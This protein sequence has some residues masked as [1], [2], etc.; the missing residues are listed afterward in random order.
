MWGLAK[1][2]I[3]QWVGGDIMVLDS[4]VTYERISGGVRATSDYQLFAY[5]A[6][7][8]FVAKV[9]PHSKTTGNLWIPA[10]IYDGSE[11]S[12]T[13]RVVAREGDPGHWLYLLRQTTIRDP[14]SHQG[15]VDIAVPGYEGRSAWGSV[16][17]EVGIRFAAYSQ[18]KDFWDYTASA[19]LPGRISGVVSDP[20]LGQSS[21]IDMDSVRQ[22]VGLGNQV[23]WVGIVVPDILGLPREVTR[24]TELFAVEFPSLQLITTDKFAEMLISD[25]ASL[26]RAASYSVPVMLLLSIQTIVATALMLAISRRRELALLRTMGLSLAQL[27]V[28]FVMECLAIAVLSSAAGFFLSRALARFL[29]GSA[30]VSTAPVFITAAVAILVASTVAFASFRSQV[31][32]SL[33][34]Y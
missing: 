28:M 5:D 17:S 6:V 10:T 20:L 26:R 16:G 18:E 32:R 1:Q 7:R 33:R 24:L 3:T 4:S 34:N 25:F 22:H 31:V 2:P 8:E 21:W 9:A 29:I 23:H 12:G 30:S 13:T 11:Q 14:A 19:V 27:H 15:V